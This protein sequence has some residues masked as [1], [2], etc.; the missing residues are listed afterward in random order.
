MS[1]PTGFTLLAIFL[2]LYVIDGVRHIVT[3]PPFVT[4]GPWVF[5]ALWLVSLVLA[6]VSVEALWKVRPWAPRA[7]TAL[8]V[9]AFAALAIPLLAR[10]AFVPRAMAPLVMAGAVMW[11]IVRYVE[12]EVRLRHGWSAAVRR[13]RR[14]P[15]PP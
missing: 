13:R 7:V 14:V 11:L 10:G 2:A 4:T 3:E 6:G 15:G 1:R 12:S 9:V 5:T 8:A